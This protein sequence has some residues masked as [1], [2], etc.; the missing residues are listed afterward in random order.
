MRS[1]SAKLRK[2]KN[3]K[4]LVLW[5][6]GMRQIKTGRFVKRLYSNM[7]IPTSASNPGQL[8]SPT[9]AGE[10]IFSFWRNETKEGLH[11]SRKVEVPRG[12]AS[13]NR[14]QKGSI[15]Q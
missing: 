11:W 14:K 15:S 3:W 9:P 10:K 1:D 13:G 8:F 12:I 5:K 6:T 2:V 4:H 7:Y